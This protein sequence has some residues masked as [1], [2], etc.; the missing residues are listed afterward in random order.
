[1]TAAPSSPRVPI[2]RIKELVAGEYGI[3]VDMLSISRRSGP[4]IRPRHLAM[5]LAMRLTP[6]SSV[7]IGKRFGDRDHSTVLY[8]CRRI[9]E[10]RLD[11][12][13][14]DALIV[15]LE[16]TLRPVPP[17][18]PEIQ[19]CFLIGPLFDRMELAA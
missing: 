3:P 7:V 14:L 19:L 15:R 17:A 13:E 1:V 6:L 10:A 9:A 8:A 4:L 2:G 11:E 12:P 16:E 5:Y 18:R